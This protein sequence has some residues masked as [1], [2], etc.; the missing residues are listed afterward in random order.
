MGLFSSK[1]KMQTIKMHNGKTF[2]YMEFV[3]GYPLPDD[4]I[5]GEARE[6]INSIK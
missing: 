5:I 3:K 4:G 2:K 6:R 1:P